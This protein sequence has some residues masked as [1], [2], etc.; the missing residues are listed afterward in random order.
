M[1]RLLHLI[2]RLKAQAS[3]TMLTTSQQ[4]AFAELEKRW[5]FPDRLNLCGPQGSGK[6]FVGWAMA[7]QHQA[8]FYASPRL[9]V[10]DQPPYP[11]DI[12][13]DNVPSE[14]KNLRR[15]LAELQ[16]RQVRKVLFITSSPT[17]LGMPLITLAPPTKADIAT[18]YENCSRLQFYPPPLSKSD[19]EKIN[20]WDVIYSV[21]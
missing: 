2:N 5:R 6:T 21:L 19:E 16:L 11:T 10:H 9:L 4:M 17:H 3:S 1:S 13:V 14:E 12:I 18:V 7:R 15:L 20:F 8:R